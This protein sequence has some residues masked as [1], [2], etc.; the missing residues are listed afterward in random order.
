MLFN[1][2]QNVITMANVVSGIVAILNA[3]K[4]F[5]SLAITFELTSDHWCGSN[6]YSNTI[7]ILFSWFLTMNQRKFLTL[8][9]S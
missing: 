8:L 3:V 7:L 9:L 5:F 2:F 4:L 6:V 1:M